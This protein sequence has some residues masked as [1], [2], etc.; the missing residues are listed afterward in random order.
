MT[1]QANQP[2]Q[3]PSP[4][5]E[6]GVSIAVHIGGLL[7]SFIVPLVL[8]LIYKDRSPYLNEHAKAALNWQILL[9]PGYV[10]AWIIMAIPIIGF[11]GGLLQLAVF[12]IN[13]IFCILSAVAASNR[14]PARY[15]VD[16][17]IVK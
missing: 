6:H 4:G 17:N 3:P 11:L 1:Q 7:T 16:L 14:Q 9:L 12:V 10:V 15:P 2:P 5:E 8:W 13:A